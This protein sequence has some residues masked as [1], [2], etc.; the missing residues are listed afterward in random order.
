MDAW[1]NRKISSACHE[2]K[3]YLLVL[4][5]LAWSL[6]RV[7]VRV[8]QISSKWYLYKIHWYVVILAYSL[9]R[10]IRAD[11]GG[12][13]GGAWSLSRWKNQKGN[14]MHSPKDRLFFLIV[15]RTDHKQ[16]K[17]SSVISLIPVRLLA[18]VFM[19]VYIL[20]TILSIVKPTRCTNVSNYF[21]LVWHYMFR[22]V[23]PC[24]IRSSRL[25]TQQ[26]AYI[27]HMPVA[28]CTVL[29]SWWYT[30]RPSETCRV[31]F[32]NEIIS[33]IGTSIWF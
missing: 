22:T 18:S 28:V 6:Y 23:F 20:P 33:Y 25:Y 11:L 9:F 4:Q 29:N 8:L 24:I 1:K 12:R 10:G 32:Q 17:W 13:G 7:T 5:P 27:W 19:N 31:P 16:I 2:S 14:L 21:I 26:Q 3:H 30:E 15:K